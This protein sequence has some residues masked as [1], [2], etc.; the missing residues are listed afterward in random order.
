MAKVK[1]VINSILS[2]G[3]ID[4]GKVSGLS[5]QIIAEMNLRVS[6]VLINFE[7]LPNLVF[8]AGEP[9]VRVYPFLQQAAKESLRAAIRTNGGKKLILN[10]VY[11]T[12]AQQHILYQVHLQD[13]SLVSQAASPGFSNHEDGLALDIQNF[14]DWANTLDSRPDWQWFGAGDEVHFTYTGSGVTDEIGF[15]GVEA[16]QSLWNKNN[17]N[18]QIGVDGDFGPQTAARMNLSPAEGFGGRRVLILSTTTPM[19]GE[20]V[21]KVQQALTNAGFNAPLNGIYDAATVAEVV[22]FQTAKKLDPDGKVGPQTR[23][24]LGIL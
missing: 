1:D 12:V 13:N 24:V 2:T 11:R 9:G 22:K 20:D 8:D 7:D 19:Q 16:F 10:S 6:G 5:Q 23:R 4:T 15:I 21:R 18:D 14:N 3:I 17:P